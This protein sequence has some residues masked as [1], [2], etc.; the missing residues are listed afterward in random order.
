[1][2]EAGSEMTDDETAAA[3][4]EF[5][6]DTGPRLKQ[7]LIA[8]LGGEAGREATADALTWAWEHWDRVESMSNPAGYLYRLARNRSISLLRRSPAYGSA[9]AVAY[10]DPLVEPGLGAALARLSPMQRMVVLL[11]HGFGWT[12]REVAD[13]LGVAVGTVQAHA[14]RGMA[15][16][17]NDLKV[18]SDA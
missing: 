10:E 6:T 12:Y 16:L 2:V 18:E 15:K 5:V 11:I 8:A 17:R 7:S 14:E 13:H 4:T 9:N 1:M 3:F